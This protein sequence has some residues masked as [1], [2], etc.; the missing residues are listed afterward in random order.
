MKGLM[1]QI[2]DNAAVLAND[3]SAADRLKALGAG[4]QGK[5]NHGER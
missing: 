2:S 3:V 5:A 4:R 1:P